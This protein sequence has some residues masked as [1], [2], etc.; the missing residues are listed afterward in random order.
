MAKDRQQQ[1]AQP[2][3]PQSPG[4]LARLRSL[5]AALP[6]LAR[7]HPVRS[8]IAVVGVGVALIGLALTAALVFRGPDR[9]DRDQLQADA[10][11]ALD[12]GDPRQARRLAAQLSSDPALTYQDHAG[13]LF[14][15]GVITFHEA[16][17]Q[18][19]PSKRRLLFL[20]AARYLEESRSRGWPPQR[21]PQGIV[22]LGRALHAGGR[23]GESLPILREA[24][25]IDPKSAPRTHWLLTDSYLHLTP[26]RLDAALEHNKSFLATPNLPPRELHAG[27]LLQSR[28]LLD[29]RQF[30]A[31]WT[32]ANQIPQTASLYPDSVILQAR[33]ALAAQRNVSPLAAPEAGPAVLIERL[34]A[35]QTKAGI[36]PDVA[37]Q[38]QLLIGM[39]YEATPD[40]GAALAQYD[41]VRRLHF[42]RPEGLAATAFQA[43]LLVQ[44]D[45]VRAVALYRRALQ[46]AGPPD[47]YVNTWLPLAEWSGSLDRAI[48]QLVAANRHAEALALTQS[49]PP[50]LPESGSYLAQARV[51][52]SWAEYLM[53]KARTE[54]A[55]TAPVTQAEARR[56]WREAGLAGRKLAASRVATRHYLDDLAQAAGDYLRGQ[57]YEQAALVYRDLLKQDPRQ[58]QPEALAGLGEALLALG[59]TDESLAALRRCIDGHPKHPATYRARWLASYALQEQDKL[60]E[61]AELLVDNLYRHALAPQS[62]DWRDS[63]F[64]YGFLKYRQALEY[65]TQSRV[66]GIDRGETEIRREALERLE[67]SHIAFDEAIRSLKEAA[68]RYPT[69]VACA[70]AR[71]CV[72]ESYRHRA[73][74]PRKRLGSVTIETTRVALNRQIQEELLASLDEYNGLIAQLSGGQPSSQSS[75]D[76]SLLR[77]CYFGRADAL[78]DLGRF[79]EAAQAYSA[80]SNRYQHE[81]EALEAYVQIASCYRRLNRL[82]EARSTLEQARVVLQRIRADA[83]FTRTT[84]YNRDEWANLLTWLRTL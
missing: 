10:L 24:L 77:N 29:Q 56:H 32:A 58:G 74:W 70:Q 79:E 48:D 38:L 50:L 71:Y 54:K 78:F 7:Q 18:S 37:A 22:I 3:A 53:E 39:C 19:D 65:E 40:S 26:P 60:A 73:K 67:E 4:W 27:W 59:K 6:G 21:K 2:P 80:A 55:E 83:D 16:E 75:I 9:A 5:V 51:E 31:A 41:R 45:P 8:G 25:V 1:S 36:D 64:A 17:E 13:P 11:A 57:G 34:R 33:V 42:G 69:A 12:A 44:S 81:P 23:F 14:I 52:R 30:E 47:S 49:M 76:A 62:S 20:V 46:L 68:Q 72:A 82:A 28:I 84:R 15:Q 63:L 35:L 43:A 61:A 66:E